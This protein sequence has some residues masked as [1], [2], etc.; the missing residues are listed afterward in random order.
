[1]ATRTRQSWNLDGQGQYARQIGWKQNDAGKLTQHKFRLGDDLKE[2]KRRDQKLQEFWGQIETLSTSQPIVWTRETLDFA[3]QVA[4]G[5]TQ[6]TVPPRPQESPEE[7]ASYVHQLQRKFPMISF[8]AEDEGT[9]LLGAL[10]IRGTADNANLAMKTLGK[11]QR[12]SFDQDDLPALGAVPGGGMLHDA[13]RSYIE[14]IKRDYFRPS[15]GRITGNART[16]IRQM[17]TLLDRHPNVPVSSLTAEAI[18]G[19]FRYWRQRPFKKG[20][21][22]PIRTKSAE[23]YISELKRFFRWLH[24]SKD[25]S[26]RM[27]EDFADIKTKVDPAPEETQQKLVQVDVFT[28][29]ELVTLN[30]YATP[31]ERVFLLLALNCGF[32]V[33]EIASL[34]IGE[35]HLFQGH[36]KRFREVLNYESTNADSFIKRVR[37]KNG[38]YGE[39]LLFPQT[40]EAVQWVL[41]RRRKQRQHDRDS[42]LLLNARGEP[43][44]KPT[45]SENRNQQIPSRFADLLRRSRLGENNDSFPRFSFGKL[46][47]TA[48]DL[49]RRFKG[50]EVAS[51]FLCHGQAVKTD[52][53]LE[54]YTNRPFGE[55]FRAIRTVQDYLQP[56]FEAAGANPFVAQPQAY[57]NVRKR[58][59]IWE[60]HLAGAPVRE[61]ADQVNLDRST[62]YRHIERRLGR[63]GGERVR[64]VRSARRHS[65]RTENGNDASS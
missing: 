56:M 36:D 46:R 44:D 21:K 5:N 9:Y 34:L 54:V 11:F 50:G 42:P 40:V 24:R 47:K 2:A 41:E 19:M 23:N 26:W 14:W 61:I 20:T 64:P 57:T 25:Y 59:R 27:P 17:E 52:D 60:M 38:I 3:K 65:G 39:F 43:Y 15:L 37:R 62:V 18:E 4:K 53:L 35:V 30:K 32:G 29:E 10:T 49:V 48:G 28:L 8:V 1:M 13:M 33:A 63:E 31:L 7:Y 55:V 22:R 45:K 12:E 6:V 51:L 58:D 16:K